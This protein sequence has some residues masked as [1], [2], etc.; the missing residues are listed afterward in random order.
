M[1]A[2][3]QAYALTQSDASAL[4]QLKA[5]NGIKGPDFEVW[6]MRLEQV[7]KLFPNNV[8][9][10]TTSDHVGE[11]LKY[12]TMIA[13][14]NH[15]N[16]IFIKRLMNSGGL[17]RI[18]DSIW[19]LPKSAKRPQI[20]FVGTIAKWM[21][22]EFKDS[23][24]DLRGSNNVGCVRFEDDVTMDRMN[25]ILHRS[26]AVL[27]PFVREIPS[28]ISVKTYEAVATGMPLLTSLEGFRGIEDCASKMQNANLLVPSTVQG[29]VK[30]IKEHILDP[31]KATEF[32]R[33]STRVM[34]TCLNSDSTKKSKIY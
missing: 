18:C 23:I 33:N 8:V 30:F 11:N 9:S 12:I 31:V 24:K 2:S 4:N 17:K 1:N 10:E 20:F 13:N 19:A 32:R 6:P 15:Q 28:G 14:N 29:Y 26:I 7:R 16:S 21:Q 22:D 34:S 3:S 5:S 27:N 25:D